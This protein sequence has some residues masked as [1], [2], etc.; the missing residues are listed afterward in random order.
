MKVDIHNHI[1]PREWPN[2]KER[3]G[4]GGFIQV[5]IL[6]IDH[7]LWSKYHENEDFRN[8]TSEPQ[9]GLIQL[10]H[11]DDGRADMMKDENFFRTIEPNCWDLDARLEDMNRT[12]V[13]IQIL[14]TVP[15]K[16]Q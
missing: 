10:K 7:T 5:F 15:D 13:D 1:L 6:T 14:S 12:G 3:Y 2:L 16:G 9:I 4:Y 8:K 11:R